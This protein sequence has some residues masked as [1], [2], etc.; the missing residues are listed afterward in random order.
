MNASAAQRL[1]AGKYR[2]VSKLGSGGSATVSLAVA[3]GIAGF[4]KLVVLKAIRDTIK[5]GSRA[6]DGFLDEARLSARLNHPNVVQVYEVVEHEGL[7]VIVMEYLD[8]PPLAALLLEAQRRPDF[9]L[10]LR[11][12]LATK[13]LAGLHHAHELRDF[14][15]RPLGLVHRDVSPH[16]VMVTYDGL[17]KLVDFGIAQLGTRAERPSKRVPG[18]LAY[19]APEQM[20]GVADRRADVFAAGILLW[21]LI[22][23][24][25]FWGVQ[26]EAAVMRQLLAFDLPHRGTPTPDMDADLGAICARALAADPRDRPATAAEL[27]AELEHFLRTHSGVVVESSIGQLVQRAFAPERVRS[28]RMLRVLLR[29]LDA[30]LLQARGGGAFE[31]RRSARDGDAGGP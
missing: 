2:V 9:S 26:S 7:P 29:E 16:N 25:R 13:V 23:L 4:S 11:L 15:G 17:V 31:Q 18:K 30:P 20:H 28:Q 6:I 1:V 19:M 3:Q 8:G 12:T 10:E 5:P 14:S 22:T 27:Q 24:Q 21:E